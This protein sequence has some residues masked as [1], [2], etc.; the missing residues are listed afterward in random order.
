[1]RGLFSALALL[2]VV[3]SAAPFVPDD[4][5]DQEWDR[6]GV[7]TLTGKPDICCHFTRVLSC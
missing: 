2:P 5:V 7:K 3:V 1:M 6:R 4:Q